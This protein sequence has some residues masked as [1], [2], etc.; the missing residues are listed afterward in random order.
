ML[1][2]KPFK[3]I[4]GVATLAALYL[5]L[6]AYR[7]NLLPYHATRFQQRW[8][9]TG[10]EPAYLLAAQAFAD[11]DGLDMGPAHRRGEHLRFYDIEI[12]GDGQYNWQWYKARPTPFFA[13]PHWWGDKQIK[14]HMPGLPL[15]MAPLA[16]C[17][18]FRWSVAFS[19]ALLVC[20]LA[21][22]L[23]WSAR[24]L[25]LRWFCATALAL[26]CFLGSAPI[27]YYATQIYPETCAGVLA[28]AAQVLLASPRARG[29]IPGCLLLTALLW[30]SPRVFGGVL[31]AGGIVAWSAL[32]RRAWGELAALALGGGLF[33]AYNYFIWHMILPTPI[34]GSSKVLGLACGIVILTSAWVA[35]LERPR[36]WLIGLAV[37]AGGLLFGG[38]LLFRAPPPPSV[39]EP[40][41]G[42]ALLHSFYN[43]P[44]I[45]FFGNDVGLLF[46]N[47]ALW[48]GVAAACWLLL[49]R[50]DE[51]LY[52]WLALFIGVLI[53]VA[54]VPEWRGGTCPAGRYGTIPAY[55]LL[56]PLL[57]VLT[58]ASDR[59]RVR[60]VTTLVVLGALGLGSGWFMAQAPNFWFRQYHPLFGYECLQPYYDALPSSE[61]MQVKLVLPW[62]LV[63]CATLGLYDAGRLGWRWWKAL[64]PAI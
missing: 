46:L 64:P 42:G 23:L 14:R 7:D 50:R 62:L 34:G 41:T 16:H 33:F 36:W 43:Q 59:C 51:A 39:L 12:M 11:G 52:L 5:L 30:L 2:T 31:L 54:I 60:L 15:L 27:A 37:L 19:E 57:R 55:L 25:P 29:R 1:F 17:E 56:V 10:D 58:V 47:P 3:F 22:L 38:Y 28:V 35:K 61:A 48:L 44:L 9:L 18:Q 45:M 63:F 4:I 13:D 26:L 20:V 49:Y 8:L 40:A 32:R 21:A 24:T 6:G 53:S